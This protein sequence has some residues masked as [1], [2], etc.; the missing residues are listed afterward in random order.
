MIGVIADPA[1]GDV[2]AE[3]FELFKT[4]WE[5]Y[6]EGPVYEVVLDGTGQWRDLNA[7]LVVRYGSRRIQADGDRLVHIQPPEVNGKLLAGADPFP[8]YGPYALF[9]SSGGRETEAAP[10]PLVE[11]GAL[12]YVI[13]QGGRTSVRLG[14]DLFG[15]IRTLLS[16]GQPAQWAAIPTLELHIDLLRRWMAASG[17]K[18][19]ELR[20]APEGYRF[21]AALTHDVDHPSLQLH[22][23]DHTVAGFLG[24]ATLGSVRRWATGR[25]TFAQLMRNW[26][27]AVRWPTVALG[28]SRDFWREFVSYPDLERGK[29]STF[30][31]IPF[32]G[33]PGMKDG[34]SAPAFRGSRY[35]AADIS[36]E[37]RELQLCGCEIGLHGLD[38]WCDATAAERERSEVERVAGAEIK[39]V[40]MHWLYFGTDSTMLLDEAGFDY[41]STVGYNGTVGFRAGTAQ[42]YRPLGVQ[43]LLELPLIVMDTALFY[44]GH[45]NLTVAEAWKR[46]EAVVAQAV[47][48]GGC[49]TVNWHDRSLAPERQWG[50]FY[51]ELV[52]YLEAQGGWVTSARE[53]VDWFR[54]RRR[55]EA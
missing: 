40:R 8:L 29:P 28:W 32:A 7:R 5:S 45:L 37:L 42:V 27:A 16:A 44:P 2:A 17:V 24:R 35:G 30:F 53:A 1:D 31:V 12:G 46:V 41:D 13:R 55:A 3:L 4:P 20:P 14:Y 26:G 9:E 10:L 21:V 6:R 49:V 19:S 39:G 47:R 51:G 23:F 36:T 22:G 15:E 33:R 25:L 52:Q 11:R 50:E 38:A 54:T 43:R 48:F 34:G 18:F